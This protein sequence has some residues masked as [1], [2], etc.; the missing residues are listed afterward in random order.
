MKGILYTNMQSL[1]AHRDEIQHLVMMK[2]NPAV[3]ALSETR[4]TNEIDDSEVN[5]PGYSLAR[6]NAENRFTGGVAIYIRN[7]IKYHQGW[8]S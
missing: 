3:L 5:V 7:D 1:I 8:V 4:L 2:M 6:C